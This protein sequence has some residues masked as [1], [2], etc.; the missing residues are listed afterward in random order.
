MSNRLIKHTHCHHSETNLL[1]IDKEKTFRGHANLFENT[2]DVL[3]QVV[4][5]LNNYNN[6][7]NNN[8]D[9]SVN[10]TITD[11]SIGG[12]DL[13]SEESILDDEKVRV[14][15]N[16]PIDILPANPFKWPKPH[17]ERARSMYIQARILANSEAPTKTWSGDNSD[18]QAFIN[19]QYRDETQSKEINASNANN[20]KI[21]VE[22]D[23]ECE[24][25]RPPSIFRR[26]S[27][28]FSRRNTIFGNKD[29]DE[30]PKKQPPPSPIQHRD[31]LKPIHVDAMR[32]LSALSIQSN[33]SDQILENTTIA[34]LIR[35]IELAHIKNHVNDVN[36]VYSRPTTVHP[37]RRTS[38]VVPKFIAHPTRMSMSHNRRSSLA[39]MSQKQFILRQNSNPTNAR[40][41]YFEI[42]RVEQ[43][44]P[45]AKAK[46]PLSLSVAERRRFSLFPNPTVMTP[47]EATP[48]IK[49]RSTTKRPISPLAMP[50]SFDANCKKS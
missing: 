43:T 45:M 5:A 9:D 22:N 47:V 46:F 34:D 33:S 6:D 23:I 7:K 13:F 38:I 49:R 3:A 11:T 18:I 16:T 37:T 21:T 26:I 35:A 10:N 30:L 36:V 15:T 42:T 17:R 40:K 50:N 1:H 2:G 31:T 39:P 19:A 28:V 29:A 27:N 44:S 32:R 14:T 48:I 20:V 4:I 12:I 8:C 24:A 41:K 25:L